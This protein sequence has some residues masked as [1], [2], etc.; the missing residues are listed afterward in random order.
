LNEIG[1][2]IYGPGLNIVE[3]RAVIN[4]IAYSL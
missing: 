2:V 4:S 1:G 3:Y